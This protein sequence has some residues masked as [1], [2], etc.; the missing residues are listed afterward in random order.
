[1]N[2]YHPILPMLP[3][4]GKVFYSSL[5]DTQFTRT[6]REISQNLQVP[7]EMSMM[8]YLAAI[9]A[10]SHGRWDVELPTGQIKPVSIA[11]M[12]VAGSGERKSTLL[13]EIFRPLKTLEREERRKH[14]ERLALWKTEMQIWSARRKVLIKTLH[15]QARQNTISLELQ[16]KLSELENH[17]PAQPGR[18]KTIYEDT[19]AE[20]L[21]QG[22][23]ENL[24][25]ASLITAEGDSVLSSAI[26]RHLGKMNAL[27]GG[28]TIT[29]DRSTTD[30]FELDNVRLGTLLMVQ[31]EVLEAY[32]ERKGERSRGSGLWS[33]YLIYRPTSLKGNRFVSHPST[34]SK[35]ET[36]QGESRLRKLYRDHLILM[37]APDLDRN[38]IRFSPEAMGCWYQLYNEIEGETLPGGRFE[39]SADHASKLAENVGRVAALMHLFEGR[40]GDIETDLLRLA[41]DICMQC[42]DHFRRLLVPL[43]QAV[44]DAHL[45]DEW[46]N[47]L[48]R[49]NSLCIK[50]NDIRRYGPNKLRNASRIN[51]ALEVMNSAGRVRFYFEGRT[52]MVQ[53]TPN[54]FIS[55]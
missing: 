18:F 33:R 25:V 42:S 53:V 52:A 30:S 21:L 41:I 17:R 12:I 15:E 46:F 37:H 14:D 43:P 51:E 26:F 3:P 22:L 23:Y 54:L 45:L 16:T 29:V 50:R 49:A 9:S 48:R 1:M 11:V 38:V 34:Q 7:I 47:R 36:E 44:K 40:K 35:H 28:E 31:P 13:G 10:A 24:P 2:H 19:S 55:P 39:M 4:P 5:P 32:Q 27:W 6:I 8:T 20:A